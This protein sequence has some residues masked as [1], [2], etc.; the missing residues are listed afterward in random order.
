[1]NKLIY[2]SCVY[3][4]TLLFLFGCSI[5]VPQ[6]PDQTST[7]EASP[8]LSPLPTH[9]P[10]PH[11]ATSTLTPF[12][13]LATEDLENKIF[14]LLRTNNGCDLPC[15]WGITPRESSWENAKRLLLYLRF[16]VSRPRNVKLL[17]HYSVF[18]GEDIP[19]LFIGFIELNRGVVDALIIQTGASIYS[20]SFQDD[21]ARYDPANIISRHGLP[22]RVVVR[23]ESLIAEPPIPIT[24][25]YSIYFFYDE[26]GFYIRYAGDVEF[27]PVYRFCPSFGPGG[28]LVDNIEIAMSRINGENSLDELT[29]GVLIL[30]EYYKALEDITDLTVEEF[31]ELYSD[32]EPVCFETP[33]DIW[34]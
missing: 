21:W 32:D 17:N 16:S 23:S 20:R 25:P 8:T 24:K 6:P 2:L 3:A 31:A 30:P 13:L 7:L 10:T 5:S 11:P 22:S 15:W 34:P 29:S 27:K 12:P 33:R 14:E 19:Y 18:E 26:L 4:I 9:T 28:N 1:M